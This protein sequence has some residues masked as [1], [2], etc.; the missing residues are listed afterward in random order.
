[1]ASVRNHIL[2]RLFL[3]RRVFSL[4]QVSFT[5]SAYSIGVRAATLSLKVSWKSFD[6]AGPLSF[7]VGLRREFAFL[8]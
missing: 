7:Q 4:D 8:S 6:T 3:V 1:M 2:Q 5:T